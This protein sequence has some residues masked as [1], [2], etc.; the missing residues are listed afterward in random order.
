M[1]RKREIFLIFVSISLVFLICVIFLEMG[2][3]LLKP[4]PVYSQLSKLA[5]AF[6]ESSDITDWTLRPSHVEDMPSMEIPGLVVSA[7][8]NSQRFRG[9][10]IVANMPITIVL[11]DSYTFGVYVADDQTYVHRLNELAQQNNQNMFYVNAGFTGGLETDQH[12]AWLVNNISR[13]NPERIVYATFPPNDI[14]GISEENW[15]KTDLGGLPI[16]WDDKNLEVNR[17]GSIQHIGANRDS[18]L[19]ILHSIPVAR[20]SHLLVV[21]ARVLDLV[22]NEATDHSESYRFLYGLEHPGFA[23]RESKY[24]DLILGMK[25]LSEASS[26]KF[27]VVLLPINFQIEPEKQDLFFT[28][29]ERFDGLTPVYYHRLEQKLS[30]L[31]ID[32][33]NIEEGMKSSSS[34]PF[35]PSN[36]EP[37]FNSNGHHFVGTSIYNYLAER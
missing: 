18:F 20:Q 33:L 14:L 2:I 3:R 36:G 21:I 12:Y 25:K 4:Q 34:G 7:S 26:T 32:V 31:E 37:H 23:E 9:P 19:S 24:L 28:G 35:F 29:M 1:T 6:Y 15:V 10:E 11:G 17:Q 8:V 22:F 27:N 16:V 30:M 13:L 5:G